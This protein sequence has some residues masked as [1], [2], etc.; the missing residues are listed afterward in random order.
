MHFY[1]GIL[2][3]LVV[4]LN[5]NS[6][7]FTRIVIELYPKQIKLVQS[8][9]ER[10]PQLNPFMGGIRQNKTRR[11]H[12]RI[13]IFQNFT[14]FS[15]QVTQTR[16]EETSVNLIYK[17]LFNKRFSRFRLAGFQSTS[18]WFNISFVLSCRRWKIVLIIISS[19]FTRSAV[20]RAFTYH[21]RHITYQYSPSEQREWLAADVRHI[22]RWEIWFI[23]LTYTQKIRSVFSSIK[24]SFFQDF[25]PTFNETS[26]E[27]VHVYISMDVERLKIIRLPFHHHHRHIVA[28]LSSFQL[29]FF[30][31]W[32]VKK[33]WQ[34]ITWSEIHGC[35]CCVA[36]ITAG[37]KEK[38]KL[39]NPSELE[40]LLMSS[41]MR[42]LQMD[43]NFIKK[44]QLESLN[45]EITSWNYPFSYY[46]NY[47]KLR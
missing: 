1:N 16:E 32:N 31:C 14:S 25:Y 13:L 20:T 19:A 18:A 36:E 23:N 28:G 27:T 22:M 21:S 43:K 8:K 24:G 10:A 30:S 39:W 35:C 11:K 6:N 3:L 42:A 17:Y 7:N 15:C 47:T 41:W 26:R 45:N 37:K 29:S 9:R 34:R 12:V 33:T 4:L 5:R 2:C 40:M 38:G 46:W 44:Q